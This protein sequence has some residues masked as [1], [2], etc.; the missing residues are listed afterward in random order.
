[1]ETT[2]VVLKSLLWTNVSFFHG[3]MPWRVPTYSDALNA[4]FAR[5]MAIRYTMITECVSDCYVLL[6]FCKG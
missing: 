4:K 1:M 2:S 5:S 3:I 6:F